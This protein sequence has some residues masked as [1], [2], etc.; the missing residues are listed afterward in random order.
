[1]AVFMACAGLPS[2][3]PAETIVLKTGGSGFGL[4]IMKFL[5]AAFERNH[6]GVRINIVPSLGSSGG[7]EATL[8]GELDFAVSGRPLKEQ[9]KKQGCR[10]VGLA[11]TPFIFITNGNVNKR[12]VT[13]QELEMIYGGRMITWP[14]G[15]RLRLVLRPETEIDT[16]VLKGLSPVMEQAVK[17]AVSRDGMIFAVTDQEN[18]DAVEKTTGAIGGS[19]LMQVLTEERRVNILSFNGVKPS[20]TGIGDGSYPL[21]K[22]LYLVTTPSAPATARRFFEFIRSKEGKGVLAKYGALSVENKESD[23]P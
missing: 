21:A 22:T 19:T 3:A 18:V 10:A 13:T 17:S 1:L 16:A 15:K 20:I 9:E 5:A 2:I 12:D 7:I 6:P 4:G 14:D 11:R 23:K 8:A